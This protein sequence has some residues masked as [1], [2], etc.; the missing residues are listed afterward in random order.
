[1][2]CF[3]RYQ[4]R[5]R[6]SIRGNEVQDAV[7]GKLRNSHSLLRDFHSR[8]LQVHSLRPVRTNWHWTPILD[9]AA[10]LCTSCS[11][12][13]ESREIEEEEQALRSAVSR[14]TIAILEP[15]Y[16]D[17]EEQ[18]AFVTPA[19]PVIGSKQT[20]V[21]SLTFLSVLFCLPLPFVVPILFLRLYYFDSRY[22]CHTHLLVLLLVIHLHFASCFFALLADFDEWL[23][24][25][26]GE[27]SVAADE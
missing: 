19:V 5:A 1:M 9:A 3:S 26:G 12:V 17:E 7:I 15:L 24:S 18:V 6:Y 20:Q 2:Q 21:W 27:H 25:K 22:L 4:T 13:Q 16:R 8:N 11:L 23:I 10:A 14:S